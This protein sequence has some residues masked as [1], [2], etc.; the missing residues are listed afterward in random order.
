MRCADSLLLFPSS[1]AL[2]YGPFVIKLHILLDGFA[3]EHGRFQ[4]PVHFAFRATSD[5]YWREIT[6]LSALLFFFDKVLLPTLHGVQHFAQHL[7]QPSLLADTQQPRVR[8]NE[9]D[10]DRNIVGPECQYW[11]RIGPTLVY[12]TIP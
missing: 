12:T 10:Q 2:E 8:L 5:V 11:Q 7:Q 6:G 4:D 9:V 1:D 3:I